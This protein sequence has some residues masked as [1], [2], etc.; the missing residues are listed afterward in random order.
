MSSYVFFSFRFYYYQ[1]I[2][3]GTDNNS[4]TSLHPSRRT[5]A[6]PAL[7]HSH[8][9]SLSNHSHYHHMSLV[10][11]LNVK[12]LRHS[13]NP[14]CIENRLKRHPS[15]FGRRFLR[16]MNNCHLRFPNPTYPHHRHQQQQFHQLPP[17]PPQL[18]PC[19]TTVL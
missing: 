6:G 18:P 10:P 2:F 4:A 16:R 7:P 11:N 3:L 8:I 1:H 14:C 13:G 15:L 5:T 19:K 17:P 12:F 9:S